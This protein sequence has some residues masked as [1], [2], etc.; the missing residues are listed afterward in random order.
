MQATAARRVAIYTRI[1]EDRSEGGDKSERHIPECE[2]KAKAEG[3]TEIDASYRDKSVSA[4]KGM[5]RPEFERLLADAKRGAFDAIVVW[6]VDRLYR[7]AQDLQRV[8]EAVRG[9]DNDPS[10]HGIPIYQVM[11][12]HPIDLTTPSG[13]MQAN[14]YATIATYEIEHKAARTRVTLDDHAKKGL[15]RSYNKNG[16]RAFGFQPNGVDHHEIE[17]KLILEA[18]RHVLAGGSIGS[19][20]RDWNDPD[21]PGGRVRT[22]RTTYKGKPTDQTWG[23]TS[24][25]TLLLRW[26]NAGIRQITITDPKA[27][28]KKSVEYVKGTWEPIVPEDEFRAL[29]A[30]LDD[31]SRVQHRGDVGRKHLL[32]HILKCGK[33]GEPMRAGSTTTRGG[34]YYRL[35]QCAGQKTRCRL[36]VDYEVATKVVTDRI[37]ERLAM[38]PPSMLELTAEERASS[39]MLR[40]RLSALDRDELQTEKSKVSQASR[41][42]LLE[43]L[44]LERD[45]LRVSLAHLDRRMAL[46]ALLLDLAPITVG[47]RVSMSKAIDARQQVRARFQALDLDRQREVIRLLCEVK[48]IPA[49]RSV[50]ATKETAAKRIII[51]DLDPATGKHVEADYLL[52]L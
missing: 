31:P 48:V 32:S 19:I 20:L 27:G 14:I 6:H 41:L 30:K 37:V 9:N 16:R 25:R 26:S 40:V 21:R 29:R 35:Y 39:T 10:D 4:S 12:G 49:D 47:K 28:R 43:A 51:T 46:S 11:S 50:R 15:P 52:D 13:R 2:A 38:A 23:Y 3:C 33:C 34:K 18:S 24:M 1:S 44:Q 8:I 22:L 7:R 36:G 5:R 42:R 45:Q 17:A